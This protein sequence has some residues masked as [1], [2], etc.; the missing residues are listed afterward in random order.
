[1]ILKMLQYSE[2]L[3]DITYVDARTAKI[4]LTIKYWGDKIHKP[5]IP[6]RKNA[7]LKKFRG[8]YEKYIK[9]KSVLNLTHHN[10]IYWHFSE[11]LNWK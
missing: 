10:I 4:V 2:V 7:A 6:S 3:G 5:L 8:T 9:S 11:K 1:M